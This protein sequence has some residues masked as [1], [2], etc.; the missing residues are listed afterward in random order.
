MIKPKFNKIVVKEAIEERTKSGLILVHQ[1]GRFTGNGVVVAVGPG[2]TTESGITIP[3]CVAVG[4]K[5]TFS[6]NVCTRIKVDGVEYLVMPD[7]EVIC[8]HV[9][10]ETE[11]QKDSTVDV[12]VK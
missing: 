5:V 6:L 3:V 4:A 11:V 12:E 1:E 8:E 9:D 10:E 2:R 7:Q